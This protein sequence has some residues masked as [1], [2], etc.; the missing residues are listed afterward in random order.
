MAQAGGGAASK[1]AKIGVV[2][3][4]IARVL[5]VMNNKVRSAMKEKYA[6]SGMGMP[7]TFREKKTRAI[8][9]KLTKEQAN[10][11]TTTAKKAADN[12]PAR[13]FAVRS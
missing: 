8:R 1:L 5:T 13:K 2:R 9:R 6:E 3:K 4:S 11:L 7:K 12:F 10:K